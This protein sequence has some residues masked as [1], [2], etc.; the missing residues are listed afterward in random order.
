MSTI[1]T[2]SGKGSPLTA[3]EVD[4][5]FT[6]LN[7][8]KLQDI[9]ADTTPQLGGNLDVNGN[10]IVSASNGNISITP[11]GTGKVV[12]DGLSWPT[13]DGSA[14][15]VLK[16]DGAGNLAF[17]TPSGG[18]TNTII[19]TTTQLIQPTTTSTWWPHIWTIATNGGVSGVSVSGSNNQITLPAGTYL[20]DLPTIRVNGTTVP[21]DFRFYNNTSGNGVVDFAD[22]YTISTSGTSRYEQANCLWTLTLATTS[23]VGFY[24]SASA[25][26]SICYWKTNAP[27]T[28]ANGD[29]TWKAGIL[30]II[31]TA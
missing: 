18:G 23:V 26:S 11:N 12:L 14:N 13:E 8:D 21:A 16:T 17:T 1:V 19:L 7:T 30:K 24:N 10:S 2:R 5:N 20:F 25:P 6:N 29:G 3:T 15:Q 22:H 31:K 28:M 27:M 4:T 9:V